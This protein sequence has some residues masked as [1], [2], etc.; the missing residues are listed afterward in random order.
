MK[1][2]LLTAIIVLAQAAMGA[3]AMEAKRMTTEQAAARVERSATY[4]D[5]VKAQ[6]AGKDI[7]SD[8]KLMERITKMLDLSLKGVTEFGASENLSLIKLI[9]VN[10]KDV[11]TEV[12]RL[13]S[14]AKDSSSSEQEKT[15][16]RKS[17]ELL[18]KAS[19]N[20]DS[21]VKNSAEAQ[22][23][24]EAVT[25]IVEISGKIASL[26]FGEASKTFVEKY[27]KA[28]AEGK[29]IEEAVRIASNGKFTEKELRECE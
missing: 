26:N 14:I 5:I 17:L 1:K 18:V 28:L 13:S 21:F 9:N 19:H 2:L 7:T 12:A 27:E 23:Q 10:S 20:V 25:K 4:K 8:A 6:E 3:G 15:M 11:L 22:K 16:S 29:T 24:K